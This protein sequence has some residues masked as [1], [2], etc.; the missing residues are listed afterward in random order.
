MNTLGCQKNDASAPTECRDR[1]RRTRRPATG[2]R[3]RS[4]PPSV[5]FSSAGPASWSSAS[6]PWRTRPPGRR[7]RRSGRA[8]RR[9]RGATRSGPSTRRPRRTSPV[10]EPDD[11][12]RRR[13]RG[14]LRGR[15]GVR[16]SR[17]SSSSPAVRVVDVGRLGAQLEVHLPDEVVEPVVEHDEVRLSARSRPA[18]R[19]AR[20]PATSRYRVGRSCAPRPRCR[21]LRPGARTPTGWCGRRAGRRR[22]APTLRRT[23]PTPS[24]PATVDW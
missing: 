20:A 12:G 1:G 21:R 9:T 16:G 3:P 24:S 6:R 18:A 22:T 8:G 14:R 2:S 5:T 4:P 19:T 23:T 11:G 15:P 7:S 17:R 13:A 10:P